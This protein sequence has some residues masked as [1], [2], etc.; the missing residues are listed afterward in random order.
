MSV[1][2]FPHYRCGYRCG[3]AWL[4]QD[5]PLPIQLCW[6]LIGP[7]PPPPIFAF[8]H[9]SHVLVVKLLNYWLQG[10]Q[11]KGIPYEDVAFPDVSA[12]RP[13]ALT[14]YVVLSSGHHAHAPPPH[15]FQTLNLLLKNAWYF[16]ICILPSYLLWYTLRSAYLYLKGNIKLA[17]QNNLYV[18]FNSITA[19]DP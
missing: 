10:P 9:V 14:V 12:G 18:H 5:S 17:P 11:N 4:G 15:L 19:K 16:K 13:W 2:Y 3:R 7:R 1:Q 6:G 8:C